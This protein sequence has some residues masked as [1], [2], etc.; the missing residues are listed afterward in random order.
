MN[1]VKAVLYSDG[2]ARG[3]PGPAGIGYVLAIEHNP[4]IRYGQYIGETTNNQAEYIALQKGLARAKAAGVTQLTCLL[5]SELVVRQLNG[6]YRVRH[7]PL[8]ERVAE[9]QALLRHFAAVEIDHIPREKNQVADQLVN[10]AIDA[11]L[12]KKS[13][14]S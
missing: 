3:N 7:G 14:L 5:D 11:A 9:I 8:Q 2:G 1:M 6:T 10:E 4:P 12:R 13:S